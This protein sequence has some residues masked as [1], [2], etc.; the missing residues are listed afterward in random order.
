MVL[1][2]PRWLLPVAWA[3][4]W[5]TVPSAVWRVLMITGCLPGTESLRDYELG[6]EHLVNYAYV[7][8]LSVVQLGTSYLTVGLASPWGRRW[9]GHDIPVVPVIVVA[10]LGGLAVTY[11]FTIS[12]TSQVLTGSRPDQGHVSGLAL[13]VMSAC[14]LPIVAWG[15]LEL[16]ATYGYWLRRRGVVRLA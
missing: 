8:G 9:R 14:Y 1:V 5:V 13:W 16:I 6:D 12:M 11:L 10:T 2:H 4:F 15:P 3:T 7:F